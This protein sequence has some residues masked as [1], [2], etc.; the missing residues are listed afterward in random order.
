MSKIRVILV[1]LKV[2]INRLNPCKRDLDGVPPVRHNTQRIHLATKLLSL[3]DYPRTWS[4]LS[5]P[6]FAGTMQ[7]ARNRRLG[8]AGERFQLWGPNWRVVHQ[9]WGFC[10]F[11]APPASDFIARGQISQCSIHWPN[12]WQ[13]RTPGATTSHLWSHQRAARSFLVPEPS[14]AICK[15]EQHFWLQASRWRLFWKPFEKRSCYVSRQ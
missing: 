4:I 10:A 5:R 8:W 13:P 6:P 15:Y 1:D 7:Q 3:W 14:T 2:E 11:G 9:E 12:A